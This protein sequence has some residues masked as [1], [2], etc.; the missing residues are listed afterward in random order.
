MKVLVVD[1]EKLARERL[2]RMVETLDDYAVAGV[3]DSGEEAVR[4]AIRLEPDIVLLDIRMPGMDGMEAGKQLATLA[5]P[6]AVI[7]CTAFGEH[8]IEA[9][10]V[11]AV[12]YLMKPVRRETLG[13]ALAKARQVNKVQ[14]G[15]I[16][17][18]EVSPQARS[19][20]HISAKTRRGIELIPLSEVKFFQADHKYV[21]VRHEGGEVLIDDTLRDLECEFGDRVVRIH[22][23]ALVMMDHLE[24]LERDPSG[25]YQVK[26]R[27]IEEK[28]DVSR[29]HVSGLRRLVQTL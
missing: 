25:H 12:G 16:L 18:D 17:G 11:N 21:T 1:D 13:D 6:P 14:I 2:V 22:R 27:G 24:G 20:T 23:N 26:M 19:R 10:D 5:S 9:F 3:A 7:F 8:A 4:Q 28:L 29:R 15:T